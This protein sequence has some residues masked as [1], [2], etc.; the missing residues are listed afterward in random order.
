MCAALSAYGQ[1][2]APAD[3]ESAVDSA[4]IMADTYADALKD[5]PEMAPTSGRCMLPSWP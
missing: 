3:I 2:A 1:A 4:L 5:K